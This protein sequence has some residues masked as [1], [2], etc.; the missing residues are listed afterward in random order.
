MT[1][2]TGV[3]G[4]SKCIE[5]RSHE[6]MS[7]QRTVGDKINNQ[8]CEPRFSRVWAHFSAFSEDLSHD[9]LYEG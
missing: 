7:L 5:H 4:Y 6:D 3:K 2:I 8:P 1:R 9:Y